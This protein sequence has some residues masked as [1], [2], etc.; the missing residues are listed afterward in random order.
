MTM[1]HGNVE[2][3]LVLLQMGCD[4]DGVVRQRNTLGKL[5]ASAMAFKHCFGHSN[6][7]T[8][9]FYYGT[10]A[11]PLMRSILSGSYTCAH[12]LIE[13]NARVDLH[14]CKHQILRFQI[15]SHARCFEFLL[16]LICFNMRF[17]IYLIVFA[18]CHHSAKKKSVSLSFCFCAARTA[19]DLAVQKHAPDSLLWQLW[20]QG[21]G[22]YASKASIS[23]WCSNA[24]ERFP[25]EEFSVTSQVSNL[26]ENESDP[27]ISVFF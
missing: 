3:I 13:S 4:K 16:V 7:M 11:T 2:T 21:A 19:F 6:A 23:W 12:L 20:K 26:E 22:D 10:N 18:V 14:N 1:G 24:P 5:L 27:M 25:V 15:A 8:A 17:N 9:L